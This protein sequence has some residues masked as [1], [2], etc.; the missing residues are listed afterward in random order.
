MNFGAKSRT[1]ER[2]PGLQTREFAHMMQH[3]RTVAVAV[4]SFGI[5]IAAA[6]LPFTAHAAGAP[7]TPASIDLAAMTPDTMPT[8]SSVFPNLRSKTVVSADGMTAALQ[9]G[10]AAKHYHA[11]ANEVQIFLQGTGTAWLGDRQVPVKPGTM[12]VIPMGTNHAGFVA[13]SG[14]LVWVSLKTPPQ[15]PADVHFVP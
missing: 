10:S 7:L 1:L 12:L 4:V 14:N 8:P 11:N 2:R 15:D 3:L 5:G 13:T 6:R 9:M